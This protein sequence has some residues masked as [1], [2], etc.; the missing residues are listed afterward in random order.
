MRPA[1]DQPSGPQSLRLLN[2]GC[3]KRFHPDW[4]NVDIAPQG[5]S[6]IRCDLS[7]GI[8][9]PEDSF[10][11]VYH[12]NV[13][14]HI[15][16]EHGSAFIRECWRVLRPGGILRVAVPDLEQ[17]CRI[18]LEKLERA[19]AGDKEAVAEYDWMLLEL[20]DQTVRE[21]SGGGMTEHLRQN[22][23]PGESFVLERIG[24]EGRDLLKA[25]RA[26]ARSGQKTPVRPWRAVRKSLRQI[27]ARLFFGK[28]AS[29]A[30]EIG[31]FR[32][33]GEVHQW[34]Y[35][36]FSL[37]RLMEDNGFACPTL[38]TPQTSRI[39]GWSGYHLEVAPD[40]RVHKPDSFVMECEKPE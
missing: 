14:E 34:M 13:L 10:D 17:I 24:A 6:V 3:G 11:A 35:D 22:P 7:R 26:Q 39:A 21:R 30:L 5:A 28:Q 18:Y 31:R 12:S 29:K 1:A 32:L 36:R 15:R 4:V 19:D 8:P 37:G 16:R 23:V 25:I 33:A 9:F 27:L 2:L 40:G 38:M 20:F